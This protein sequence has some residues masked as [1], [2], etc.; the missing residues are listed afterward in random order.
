M[1][2][3]TRIEKNGRKG[4]RL[5]DLAKQCTAKWSKQTTSNSIFMPLEAALSGR[6]Q[7][8]HES[9]LIGKLR[10]IKHILEVCC[11]NSSSIDNSGYGWLIAKDYAFKVEEEVGNGLIDWSDL[12]ASLRTNTLILS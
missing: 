11:L 1:T 8:I 9:E 4:H 12:Q 7:P 10:H 2:G 5:V 6:S 3:I